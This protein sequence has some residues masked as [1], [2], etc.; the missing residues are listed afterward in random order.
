MVALGL[1][2]SKGAVSRYVDRKR[3][4]LTDALFPI[5]G[6][7]LHYQAR[8]DRVR[9]YI[10][11]RVRE[12]GRPVTL[13]THSLGS[14]AA[15]ELLATEPLDNVAL[16]VTVGSPASLFYELDALVTFPYEK[17]KKLPVGFPAWLN[18]YD[19]RDVIA[20]LA[21]PVFGRHPGGTR[22]KDFQ[23]DNRLPAVYA[24]TSYWTNGQIWEAIDEF[25]D[26]L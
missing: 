8:G 11:D 22:V 9:R 10:A 24:H 21:E 26:G 4:P 20:H 6:D 7:I 25:A 23:V 3:R 19:P 16:L 5:P 2:L 18:I 12:V 14:V 1:Q 15:V 13:L 17:D